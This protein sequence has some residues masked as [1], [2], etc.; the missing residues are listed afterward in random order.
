MSDKIQQKSNQLNEFLKTVI[1][2][3]LTKELNYS[4]VC[5]SSQQYIRYSQCINASKT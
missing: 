1:A 2:I 3:D 4:I 5:E